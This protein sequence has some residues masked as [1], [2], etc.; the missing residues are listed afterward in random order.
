MAK[1]RNYKG[2]E[3]VGVFMGKR[4]LSDAAKD[5]R[6]IQLEAEVARLKALCVKAGHMLESACEIIAS[7]WDPDEGKGS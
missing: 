3:N 7:E 2:K 5:A 6:I 4:N 1:K